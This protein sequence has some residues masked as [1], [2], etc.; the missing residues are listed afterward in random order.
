VGA[1]QDQ[2][3]VAES[4][5]ITPNQV[6]QL[7]GS[8][9][10][11]IVSGGS[12]E[13]ALDGTGPFLNANE[14]SHMT[15]VSGLARTLAAI[16]ALALALT[17]WAAWGLRADRRRRGRALVI[18][19]STVGVLAVVASVTAVVAFEPLFIAFHGVFFAAGTWSFPPGSH[20]TGLFPEALFSEAAVLAGALILV[21]A[22]AVGLAGFLQMRDRDRC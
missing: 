11:D 21:S 18:A 8:I 9:L 2:F 19:A 4:L 20:L 5:G 6:E 12:F 1:A 14:R 22:A 15:D 10:W 16:D 17:I 3:G 13:A 7:T